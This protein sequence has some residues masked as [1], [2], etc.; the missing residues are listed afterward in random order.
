MFGLRS[1]TWFDQRQGTPNT[2]VKT[3][4]IAT[5]VIAGTASLVLI[6]IAFVLILSK[7]ARTKY[8]H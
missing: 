3:L 8:V 1:C 2:A 4:G 7:R 5:G 6:I